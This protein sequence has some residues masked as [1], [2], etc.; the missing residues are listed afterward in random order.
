MLVKIDDDYLTDIADAIRE[1]AESEETY[2]PSEMHDAIDN[3][4]VFV[5]QEEYDEMEE[6]NP[7]TIYLIEGVEE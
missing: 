4:Y 1:T 2:Y 5:T 6:H 7:D 3:L